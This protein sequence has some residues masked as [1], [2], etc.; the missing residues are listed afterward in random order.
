MEL[1][2]IRQFVALSDALNFHR[3]AKV[4]HMSQPPLSISI[5]K[6]EQ[7]IGVTL[8]DRQTR[9]VALTEAGLAALPHARKIL[10][11]VEAMGD[12]A[13]A[14]VDGMG[15][16]LSVGFVGSAVY[17]LLPTVVPLFRLQRPAVDLH[18]REA[19][20]LEIIRGLESGELDVGV[21]RT[22]VFDIGDIAL[23]ALCREEMIL[24]L[25]KSHPL[26][27]QESMRLEDLRNE[28]FIGYDRTRL[29]N[30]RN[31]SLSACTMA[32]FQPQIVEE[33]AHL[34]TLI[35]LVESGI[36]MALAPAVARIPGSNRVRHARLTVQG[37]PIMIGLA[38]ATRRGESRPARDAFVAAL[39]QAADRQMEVEPVPSAAGHPDSTPDAFARAPDV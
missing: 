23:E 35:A 32:G 34:H 3:A 21:L 6:L 22:P 33:A 14:A 27:D 2:Q 11:G 20:T 28:A 17:A 39:R 12:A 24:L 26:R 18:L 7:E 36:G 13:R 5:R 30:Y 10:A 37:A 1:R 9:G 29:P 15:G 8:F 16:Q 4:L 25:P 31:L 38:L 19:T